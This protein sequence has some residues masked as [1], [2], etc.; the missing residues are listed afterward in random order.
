MFKKITKH[1]LKLVGLIIFTFLIGAKVLLLIVDNP[2]LFL[3]ISIL[4]LFYFIGI[5]IFY[6]NETKI[7][8]KKHKDIFSVLIILSAL[9]SVVVFSFNLSEK[10][11][12]ALDVLSAENK[13]NNKV[14]NDIIKGESHKEWLYWE[15]L[16]VIGYRQNWSEINKIYSRDCIEHYLGL[17]H[18]LEIINNMT[19]AIN[20]ININQIDADI[21]DIV[22][23]RLDNAKSAKE[24]LNYIFVNCKY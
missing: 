1:F 18:G 10:R 4:S 6:F 14:L 20:N 13:I 3:N 23:T 22:K 21:S 15:Y 17:I 11:N 9:F 19:E 8:V 12:N 16:S 7:L 24:S 5:L 2:A